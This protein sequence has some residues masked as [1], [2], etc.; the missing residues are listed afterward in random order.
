MPEERIKIFTDGA[1]LGNPG[2]GGFAWILLFQD[3]KIEHSDSEKDT[4]NNRMELAAVIDA[5]RYYDE[6]KKSTKKYIIEIY[7][8]SNLIVQAINQRWLTSWSSKGW[9]KADKEPVKNPDLWAELLKYLQKY[10]VNFNWVKGHAGDEYNERCDILARDAA[11]DQTSAYHKLF[12]LVKNPIEVSE[13]PTGEKSHISA[14]MQIME[15]SDRKKSDDFLFRF[16]RKHRIL[17]I[18]Q[19][20]SENNENSSTIVI[21][22]SNFEEFEEKFNNLISNFK[23]QI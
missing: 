13:N 22:K 19:I 1:C 12:K 15:K 16:D 6:N 7:T 9:K 2:P 4:T 18:E 8:D 23:N 21:N 11:K 17:T 14:R 10:D 5:L 20:K 3:R